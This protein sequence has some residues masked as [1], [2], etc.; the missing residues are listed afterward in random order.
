LDNYNENRKD[1]NY[2]FP[3]LLPDDL[4]PMQIENRKHKILGQYNKSLKIMAERAG[5]TKNVTR[6]SFCGFG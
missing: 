1:T 6:H 5:I 4:T 3:I 2:V